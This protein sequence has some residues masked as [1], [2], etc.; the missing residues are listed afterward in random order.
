MGNFK[1]ASWHKYFIDQATLVSSKSKDRSTKVGAVV[2]GPDREIRST[3]FNGFPRGVNDDVE[4]RH[5]RA[6]KYSYTEHAERNAIYNATRIGVSLKGCTLYLNFVPVPCFDCARGVIQSGI[7]TVI[8]PPI[9]FTGK[10]DFWK[11]NLGV[12]AEMMLEAGVELYV[13]N[14]DTEELISYT[15]YK[16]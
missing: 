4:S 11:D 3:G 14:P 5:E 1:G 2:V 15:E 9:P 7:S 16:G 12:G 8:G 10:G 6:A 13:F